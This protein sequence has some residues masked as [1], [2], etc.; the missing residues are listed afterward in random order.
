MWMSVTYG[1]P[2]DNWN[3]AVFVYRLKSFIYMY[4]Y[5]R[6][7]YIHTQAIYFLKM[8]WNNQKIYVQR[9]VR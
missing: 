7:V 8:K 9:Y 5:P 2:G 1:S 6:K 4:I 3:V